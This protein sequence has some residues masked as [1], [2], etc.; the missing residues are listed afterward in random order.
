MKNHSTRSDPRCTWH[1]RTIIQNSPS[2]QYRTCPAFPSNIVPVPL[3]LSR[4]PFVSRFPFAFPFVSRFPLSC[5]YRT[6]PA[7]PCP[8]SLVPLNQ[9]SWPLRLICRMIGGKAGS[10][11]FPFIDVPII[12]V[13]VSSDS[14]TSGAGIDHSGTPALTICA[15]S[16][17]ER[18]GGSRPRT[19]RRAEAG[20]MLSNSATALV[21]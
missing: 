19:S 6:C 2:C 4:F 15:C 21:P 20:E 9:C 16:S 14:P 10:S 11:D 17:C 8:L 3:S 12:I 5:Q 18:S 7:F 1:R 13:G